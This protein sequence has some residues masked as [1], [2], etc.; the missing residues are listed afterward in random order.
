MPD[1]ELDARD[2]ID[3]VSA[4]MK[5]FFGSG[6]GRQQTLYTIITEYDKY[7]ETNGQWVK[8]ENN[9]RGWI[10]TAIVREGLP[11]EGTI[12]LRLE[13]REG[14]THAELGGGIPDTEQHVQKSHG[15]N[16]EESEWHALGCFEQGCGRTQ[17]KF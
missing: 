1:M 15:G 3:W 4:L 16:E 14:T 9:E 17:F 12:K 7:Q 11:K 6:E 2:S 5:F 8:I 10:H 13:G